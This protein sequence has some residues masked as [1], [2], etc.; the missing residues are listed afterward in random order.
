[1][2]YRPADG[3]G[4]P[5]SSSLP[6]DH[7]VLGPAVSASSH[8]SSTKSQQPPMLIKRTVFS[9]IVSGDNAVREHKKHFTL[10]NLYWTGCFKEAVCHQWKVETTCGQ[11]SYLY[12]TL[13]ESLIRGVSFVFSLCCSSDGC[14]VRMWCG[15]VDGGYYAP[16]SLLSTYS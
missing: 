2:L 4:A 10:C 6:P 16:T 14:K 8:E 5:P 15:G 1:M 9:K 7:R 11:A 3:A 13:K 12:F